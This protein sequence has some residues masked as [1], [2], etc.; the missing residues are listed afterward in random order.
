MHNRLKTLLKKNY[1]EPNFEETERFINNF[2]QYKIKKEKEKKTNF[3]AV[4]LLTIIAVCGLSIILKEN[5]N[6]LDIQTS[7]GEV[8]KWKK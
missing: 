2:H 8:Q 3:L 5:N 7:S 1:Y 4:L 6:K